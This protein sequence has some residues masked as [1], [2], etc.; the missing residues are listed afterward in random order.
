MSQPIID[1][2]HTAAVNSIGTASR[3][4]SH[5]GSPSSR[6]RRMS[7]FVV[8]VVRRSSASFPTTWKL[9]GRG[10]FPFTCPSL[11]RIELDRNFTR[12]ALP[13]TCCLHRCIVHKHPRLWPLHRHQTQP[14]HHPS[15]LRQ[16]QGVPPLVEE[17]DIGHQL[18]GSTCSS[19][20]SSSRYRQTSA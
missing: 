12:D 18:L 17:P 13:D 3:C 19:S 5:H 2:F 1:I 20:L 6:H 16:R 7:S 15:V 8:V 9:G 4:S 11:F 10:V 14:H